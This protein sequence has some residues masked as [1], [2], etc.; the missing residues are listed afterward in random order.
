MTDWSNS[1]KYLNDVAVSIQ[2]RKASATDRWWIV[3]QKEAFRCIPVGHGRPDGFILGKFNGTELN[4]GLTRNEWEEIRLYLLT[5]MGI[6][7]YRWQP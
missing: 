7:D 2:E 6:G 5:W 1:E 4:R 3:I